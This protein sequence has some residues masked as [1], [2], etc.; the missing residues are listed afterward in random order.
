LRHLAIR[1]IPPLE[2]LSLVPRRRKGVVDGA[3]EDV[4]DATIEVFPAEFA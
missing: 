2:E 1:P 3:A 4:E